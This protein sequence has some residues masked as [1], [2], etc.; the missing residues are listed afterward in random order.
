MVKN[1]LGLELQVDIHGVREQLDIEQHFYIKT[2]S[3][4]V[5]VFVRFKIGRF[6]YS[7]YMRF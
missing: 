3:I 5:P 2:Y 1:V 4:H 7:I 6:I